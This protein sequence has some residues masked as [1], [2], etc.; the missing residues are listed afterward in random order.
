MKRIRKSTSMTVVALALAMTLGA[1]TTGDDDNPGTTQTTF[2]GAVTTTID[3]GAT[4]TPGST[5][6][7]G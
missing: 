2:P 1:C 7:S 5:T 4:T 6:T 3:L